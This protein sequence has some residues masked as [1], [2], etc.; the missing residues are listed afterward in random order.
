MARYFDDPTGLFLFGNMPNVLDLSSTRNFASLSSESASQALPTMILPAID[1]ISWGKLSFMD[2]DDYASD[3][4]TTGTAAPDTTSQGVFENDIDVD[5]FALNVVAGQTYVVRYDEFFQGYLDIVDANGNRVAGAFTDVDFDTFENL[6]TFTAP[7]SGTLYISAEANAFDTT[8]LPVEFP[9]SYS[10]NVEEQGEQA[11]DL[12]GDDTTT[13]TAFLGQAII[14]DYENDPD[15][16]WYQ[17]DFSA[18]QTFVLLGDFGDTSAVRLYDSNSNEIDVDDFV[19]NIGDSVVLRAPDAGTYYISFESNGFGGDFDVTPFAVPDDVGDD[20][21]SSGSIAPGQTVLGI[22]DTVGDA[23]WY[24]FTASSSGVQFYVDSGDTR[25]FSMSIIDSDGNEAFLSLIDT[26]TVD[27]YARQYYSFNAVEGEDYF[28][29]MT[30]SLSQSDSAYRLTYFENTNDD[31]AGD[32]STSGFLLPDLPEAGTHEISGEEDWFAFDAVQGQRYVV[33]VQTDDDSFESVNFYDA[34]GNIYFEGTGT[35]FTPDGRLF[36]FE[37]TNTGTYYA[38]V[39]G[40]GPAGTQYTVSLESSPDVHGSTVQTAFAISDGTVLTGAIDYEGDKDWFEIQLGAGELWS[41]ALDNNSDLQYEFG[42]F[43][44]D[45]NEIFNQSSRDIESNGDETLS[46]IADQSGTYFVGVTSFSRSGGSYE[47]TAREL[48]DDYASD[49]STTGVFDASGSAQ[50]RLQI[51]GDTDW[52]AITV[53]AGD[54]YDF[55]LDIDAD[56][57]IGG[58]TVRNADGEEVNLPGQVSTSNG[59]TLTFNTGGTYYVQVGTPI[60]FSPGHGAN[61]SYRVTADHVIDE[62]GDTAATAGTLAPGQ[63]IDGRLSNGIDVDWFAFDATAGDIIEFATSSVENFLTFNIYDASGEAIVPANAGPI[64]ILISGTY[65][66]GINNEFS[67]DGLVNYTI[68]LSTADAPVVTFDD[69]DNT[70]AGTSAS[71]GFIGLGGSD[72]MDGGGGDDSLSGGLGDD[73]L[74]GGE[75]N[76]TLSGGSGADKFVFAVGDG[77][78][79]ITDFN[80][81]EDTIELALSPYMSMSQLR[82]MLT[83][84]DG[85]VLM[86]MGGGD[87]VRFEGLTVADFTAENFT[88]TGISEDGAGPFRDPNDLRKELIDTS[89]SSDKKNPPVMEVFDAGADGLALDAAIEALN[90]NVLSPDEILT[91]EGVFDIYYGLYADPLFE[92]V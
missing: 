8:G 88:L 5:W 30:E 15:V 79:V 78:D 2:G 91:P 41:F 9:V 85:Y 59:T 47:L 86:D 24:G 12:A 28:V 36:F 48:F 82:A 60:A 56:F 26:E 45:G 52:F 55:S 81:S 40:T 90:A 68:G 19:S 92:V 58:L 70:V 76:D 77:L 87:S 49:A 4:T 67:N 6:L 62:A 35:S 61:L 53:A 57:G 72:I 32:T 51:V 25:A 27:G 89:S 18:A 1:S 20:A 23:D 71:E 10:F 13:G 11:P 37:A 44:A 66:L 29:I 50:G 14:G 46:V 54:T 65:Y 3:A 31:Y 74:I 43:D 16:D 7:Q 80:A 39:S 69:L 64:E 75:G 73:I 84:H 21:A 17:I 42:L 83:Q 33:R 38:G 63:I 22:G 34:D